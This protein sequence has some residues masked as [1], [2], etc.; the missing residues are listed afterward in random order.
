METAA[1]RHAGVAP[2]NAAVVCRVCMKAAT[3]LGDS[4]WGK[5]LHAGTRGELGPDAPIGAGVIR[6]CIAGKAGARS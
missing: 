6:A 3:V 1:V 2:L 4:E 5:A